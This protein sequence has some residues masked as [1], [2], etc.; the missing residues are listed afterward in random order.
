MKNIKRFDEAV[1]YELV[2]EFGETDIYDQFHSK[3]EDLI[4]EFKIEFAKNIMSDDENDFSEEDIND[5]AD[6]IISNVVDE[7]LRG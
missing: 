6:E 5:S 1:D 2:E 7:I 4:K 3:M